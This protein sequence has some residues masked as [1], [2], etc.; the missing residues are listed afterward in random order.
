MRRIFVSSP[1]SHYSALSSTSSSCLVFKNHQ[2]QQQYR[3]FT[4]LNTCV[5]N[6]TTSSEEY[7]NSLLITEA[8]AK[9]IKDINEKKGAHDR[10]LRVIVES[11]GCSGYQVEFTFSKQVEQD[12]QVFIHNNYP[13]SKVIADSIT[14]SFIKGS[15]IDFVESMAKTAFVLEKNPN[16]ETGCS[17][18]TSFSVKSKE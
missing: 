13:E 4:S 10:M 2:Q 15:T 6:Q 14:M 3:K 7:S 17:C 12:D 5:R 9:R 11:G 16:A 8:C 1:S 18:G